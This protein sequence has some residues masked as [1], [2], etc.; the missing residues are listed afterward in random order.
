MALKN[1]PFF[2]KILNVD[3]AS[4]RKLFKMYSD[5]ASPLSRTDLKRKFL[6]EASAGL[7]FTKSY[8]FHIFTQGH[9]LF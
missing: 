6:V 7:N 9:L 3:S 2:F 4:C 8:S 1:E 5:G